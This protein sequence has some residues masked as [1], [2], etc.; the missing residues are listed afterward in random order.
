MSKPI[1]E[2]QEPSQENVAFIIDQMNKKLQ[3][4]NTGMIRSEDIDLSRYEDLLDLYDYIM[5]KDNYSTSETQ[6][7]VSELGQLRKK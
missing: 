7:I 5:T 2:L 4:V 6:M 3:V 1:G